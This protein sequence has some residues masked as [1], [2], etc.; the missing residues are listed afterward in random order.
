MTPSLTRTQDPFVGQSGLPTFIFVAFIGSIVLGLI[1][2][3]TVLRGFAV[4]RWARETHGT[5][6]GVG[7]DPEAIGLEETQM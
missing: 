7:A 6:R 2:T 1:V 5:H 3:W 4:G